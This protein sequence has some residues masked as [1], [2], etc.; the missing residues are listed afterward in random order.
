MMPFTP[1]EQLISF[2][3]QPGPRVL[4]APTESEYMT[5]A[6]CRVIPC[7]I[8]AGQET[9]AEHNLRAGLLLARHGEARGAIV[10]AA[11]LAG[12]GLL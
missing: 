5:A 4:G 2:V 12:L 7:Q 1:E 9:Y 3:A 10:L 8:R 6:R 11:V